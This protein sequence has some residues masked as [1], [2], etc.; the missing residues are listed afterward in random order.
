MIINPA[1]EN[2]DNHSDNKQQTEENTEKVV[3]AIVKYSTFIYLFYILDQ[4]SQMNHRHNYGGRKKKLCS[5]LSTFP[6]SE[7]INS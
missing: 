3:P 2:L 5:F 6:S 4:I 7:N 1:K